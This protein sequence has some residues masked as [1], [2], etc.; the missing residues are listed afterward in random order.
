VRVLVLSDIHANLEALEACLQAAPTHDLVVNLGDIVGYG[1]SPNEVA[2]RSRE[3]GHLVVRGNHDKACTGQMD[4]H[5][6][7][8]VAAAAALWTQ[9]SLEP[10]NLEWLH[11]LSPGPIGLTQAMLAADSAAARES[12]TAEVPLLVH[13]SPL[14][15]DEYV[16][17]IADALDVL[18][19][20]QVRLT[21]FG[22][23]HIQGGF[24]LR[25]DVGGQ[26]FRPGY[27]TQDQQE[28]IKMSLTAQTR[29]LI[30]PGSVGQPRDGD[31]RAAFLLFDSDAAQVT[32]Y[33]VPYD[34]AGA[35]KRIRD[36]KL[37][38]RL[39]TRLSEGR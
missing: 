20:S 32:F 14:N 36:A 10:E 28:E 1:A 13:G 15:E 7:N 22:H 24:S 38:P 8:P 2:N 17:S 29:Y 18:M 25:A 3:L 5:D 11:H 26:A 34:I 6:F 33:R 30:N 39:A 27:S 23:T 12:E 31:W 4:L 21:F 37:P 35:Q 19:R 9:E 16:I